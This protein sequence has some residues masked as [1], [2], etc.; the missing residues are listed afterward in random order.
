MNPFEISDDEDVDLSA[1]N[2]T[3]SNG[4]EYD[5]RERTTSRETSIFLDTVEDTDEDY[6]NDSKYYSAN[7]NM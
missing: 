2:K 7:S 6:T 3:L 1:L 4:E 5:F